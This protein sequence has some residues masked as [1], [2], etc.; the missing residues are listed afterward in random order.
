MYSLYMRNREFEYFQYMNG[1][2]DEASWQS[3]QQVIVFNHS[4]E[5][6]KKWWDEI[7][8]D[9]VDPEFAVIVDALLADAEPANLYKRMSTWADP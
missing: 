2:L 1:V 7:G 8:R 9:L 6:G 5:L 4:T 3:N